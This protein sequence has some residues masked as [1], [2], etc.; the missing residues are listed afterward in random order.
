M[1]SDLATNSRMAH[2]AIGPAETGTVTYVRGFRWPCHAADAGHRPLV[3]TDESRRSSPVDIGGTAYDCD[4]PALALSVGI[5][6]LVLLV[7][8]LIWMIWQRVPSAN[9]DAADPSCG[10]VG[11]APC[12][13][14][15][16][17]RPGYPPLADSA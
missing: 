4:R 15:Y 10:N 14:R 9:S 6:V 11:N 1:I 3:V 16:G 17:S 8:T 5:W 12:P 7:A 13:Q 2:S